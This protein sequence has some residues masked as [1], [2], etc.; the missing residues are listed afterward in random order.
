VEGLLRPPGVHPGAHLVQMPC[1]SQAISWQAVLVHAATT[2]W[3]GEVPRIESEQQKGQIPEA[4]LQ[5]CCPM[6]GR[7]LFSPLLGK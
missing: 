1:D 4:T 2:P 5:H 3:V 7:G 6:G